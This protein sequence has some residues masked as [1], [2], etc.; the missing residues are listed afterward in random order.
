MRDRGTSF[1]DV[2]VDKNSSKERSVSVM[3]RGS[4]SLFMH[5]DDM[6][7]TQEEKERFKKLLDPLY[8]SLDPLI[9]P[10]KLDCSHIQV[11]IDKEI[12]KKQQL[13]NKKNF[14]MVKHKNKNLEQVISTI[15]ERILKC[16]ERL[17]QLTKALE[18]KTINENYEK[19][20]ITT[21]WKESVCSSFGP[22]KAKKN[23]FDDISGDE[24]DDFFAPHSINSFQGFLYTRLIP[25][26]IVRD[27][28]II[29]ICA[30]DT[31]RGNV[32]FKFIRK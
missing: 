26:Q 25:V 24:L 18:I 21:I 23:L 6:F 20:G 4:N 22:I 2:V 7:Q 28:V 15:K 10:Y 8:N 1:S 5:E 12:Y 17:N 14:L 30:I 27:L 11:E 13:T 19:K 9:D 29:V 32:K 16:Q 3:E 31:A